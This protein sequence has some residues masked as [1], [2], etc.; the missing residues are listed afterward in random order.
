LSRSLHTDEAIDEG[1]TFEIGIR[2]NQLMQQ[3]ETPRAQVP[4]VL[5]VSARM[6][7]GA[8]EDE[9]SH[10]ARGVR[11]DTT[12]AGFERLHYHRTGTG[13][14]D[15][16]PNKPGHRHRLPGGS[17]TNGSVERWSSAGVGRL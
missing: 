11:V 3:Y 14:T 10:T 17:W 15:P 16:A 12:H 2:R 7:Q 9:H 6:K 8:K 4:P 13:M 5:D 1:A